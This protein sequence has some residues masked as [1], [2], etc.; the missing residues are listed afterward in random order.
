MPVNA[1]QYSQIRAN[2]RRDRVRGEMREFESSHSGQIFFRSMPP[3]MRNEK[4]FPIILQL[5]AVALFLPW[6]VG[7]FVAV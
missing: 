4:S 5:E 1:R 7:Q 3:P 6:R 2:P